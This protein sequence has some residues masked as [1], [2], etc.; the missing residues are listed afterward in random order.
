MK[1][2]DFRVPIQIARVKGDRFEPLRALV[3]TGST[4]TWVPR[5][6]L[7]RLGVLDQTINARIGCRARRKGSKTR[8][9]ISSVTTPSRASGSPGSPSTTGV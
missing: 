6:V 8:P 5:D 3:D 4:F 7:E 2:G 9:R 1:R